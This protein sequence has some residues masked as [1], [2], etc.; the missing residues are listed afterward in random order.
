[1]MLLHSISTGLSGCVGRAEAELRR[2]G[3][4]EREK[5]VEWSSAAALLGLRKENG[6][7][8]LYNNIIWLHNCDHMEVNV[9]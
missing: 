2:H 4:S 6:I 5:R 8:K 1:M 3:R 7:C 9:R